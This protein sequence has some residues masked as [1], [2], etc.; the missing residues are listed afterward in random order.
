MGNSNA[1]PSSVTLPPKERFMKHVVRLDDGCLIWTSAKSATGAGMISGMVD[2]RRRP[3]LAH[4]VAYEYE[5]GPI[6]K[7]CRIRQTCKRNDCVE[8]SH[9]VLKLPGRV[10]D[11]QRK[12]KWTRCCSIC[13]ETK[14]AMHFSVNPRGPG[15]RTAWCLVCGRERR[16][17]INAPGH[18]RKAWVGGQCH[19]CGDELTSENQSTD[20]VTPR[21]LGGTDSPENLVLCCKPCNSSKKHFTVEQWREIRQRQENDVPWFSVEQLRFFKEQGIE[22]PMGEPFTFYFETG[23][24]S[25]YEKR[26]RV[27]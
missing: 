22:I 5:H 12:V 16:Q 25:P 6:P 19:Y 20:H 24:V 23:I 13:G 21:C 11:Y 3:L 27:R 18:A 7:G 8:P 1:S 4:R 10:R 14:T 26:K 9:L 15:G 2:G 17:K